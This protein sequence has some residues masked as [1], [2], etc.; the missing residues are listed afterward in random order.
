MAARILVIDDDRKIT[1]MLRRGLGYEGYHVDT[2]HS[3]VGGLELARE[4]TPDLVILDIMMAGMDGLEVCR[5]IRA[6]S[7]VPILM[8]TARDAVADRVLGLET[9]ADD[10][11]VKPF[12]FEELL[13]RIRAILRRGHVASAE[14][15]EYGDLRLDTF[16]RKAF[17]KAREIEL[18]TTEYKILELFLRH[19]ER[20]FLKDKILEEVWG[21][22]F[23]GDS[24]VLEV[25]IRYLRNKLEEE[26]EKRLI[27]TMR[28]S[29]YVL[30]QE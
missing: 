20:V 25:Y 27:H 21:Y 13:A 8:L 11:L 19:P 17:R 18:T 15:M 26:G 28:G 5:K 16:R 6:E 2:G 9:G 22:D 12:A 29:G 1:D 7:K 30:R 14:V 4:H 10:Y 3:G 23:G 24:N